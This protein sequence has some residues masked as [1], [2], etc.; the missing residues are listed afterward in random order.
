MKW[1]WQRQ[2]PDDRDPEEPDDRS[3]LPPGIDPKEFAELASME[4]AFA[5]VI[6]AQRQLNGMLLYFDGHM[7]WHRE[8]GTECDIA[9]LPVHVV[10]FLDELKMNAPALQ[11]VLF[12]VLL[13]D[14]HRK[15]GAQEAI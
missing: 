3:W 6:W 8:R 2:P 14:Y 12:I 4:A 5:N 10:Q 7:A 13:K 1:P 11:E 15:F 9:C